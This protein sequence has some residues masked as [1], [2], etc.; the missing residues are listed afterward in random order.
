MGTSAVRL[1]RPNAD[2]RLGTTAV[3]QHRAIDTTFDEAEQLAAESIGVEMSDGADRNNIAATGVAYRDDVQAGAMAQAMARQH[4]ANY[5]LIPEVHAA[6]RFLHSSGELAGVGTVGLYDLGSSGL[7]VS[8]VDLGTGEIVATERSLDVGGN[9]FDALIRDNQLGRQQGIFGDVDARDFEIRC[10]TAKEQLSDSGA[11]CLPG[12][13][14]LILLSREAFEAMIAVPVENS[15]RMVKD[16]IDRSGRTVDALVLV[17][18]GSNIPLVRDTLGS[19]TGLRLITPDE[20]ELVAAKGAALL[21]TPVESATNGHASVP[22]N[23]H[24]AVPTNGHAPVPTNGHVPV[25]TNGHAAVQTNGHAPVPTNHHARVPTNDLT[26]VPTNDLTQVP[27]NGHVPV[28]TN[29]HAQVPTNNSTPVP[30]NEHA[31]FENRAPQ[32]VPYDPLKDPLPTEQIAYSEAPAAPTEAYAVDGRGNA[33]SEVDA[34]EPRTQ[35]PAPASETPR[36]RTAE[37]DVRP[38]SDPRSANVPSWLTG[39]PDGRAATA[40]KRSRVPVVAAV[41]LA[42]IAAIGLALG[43]GGTRESE[44]SVQTPATTDAPA[45]PSTAVTTTNPPLT[46]TAPSTVPPTTTPAPAPVEVAPPASNN[47]GGGGGGN[48]PAPAPAPPPLIPGLPEFTLPN[49]VL[50]PL[51]VIPGF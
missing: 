46:T 37:P 28:P 8:I 48:A 22:T 17:G 9:M 12:S 40:P 19:W 42:V 2:L 44:T 50:P 34:V 47:G 43:Y 51:P 30:T 4:I 27:T 41:V 35:S 11:V 29:D 14:G 45:A 20:P 6:L 5:R 18:G 26:Q 3:F 32:K 13:G 1:A 36:N 21:A 10:R 25:Q 15:A 33:P 49:I 31:E 24:A 16:L 39:S 23:G 38:V 7:S